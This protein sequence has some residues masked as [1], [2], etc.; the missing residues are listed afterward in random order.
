MV[1]LPGIAPT[2]LRFPTWLSCFRRGKH[3]L[4]AANRVTDTILGGWQINSITNWSSGI[5]FTLGLSNCGS[6]TDS[7]LAV[8]TSSALLVG[9]GAYNTAANYVP[10]FGQVTLVHQERHL[11]ARLGKFGNVGRNTLPA[12]ILQL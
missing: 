5:P 3:F 11:H 12:R 8:Q 10:Y 7:G 4:A 1:V 9:A 2:S 6:S